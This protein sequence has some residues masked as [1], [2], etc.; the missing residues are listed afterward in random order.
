MFAVVNVN[1][2]NEDVEPYSVRSSTRNFYAGIS[3][4]KVAVLYTYIPD[5]GLGFANAWLVDY[6]A[7]VSSMTGKG[8]TGT[9]S[10]GIHWYVLCHDVAY[11]DVLEIYPALYNV[12]LISAQYD[13]ISATNIVAVYRHVLKPDVLKSVIV[14]CFAEIEGTRPIGCKLN[15]DLIFPSNR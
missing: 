12:A 9:V 4:S 7:N 15:N 13:V 3:T 11:D 5:H 14:R 10:A 2:I 1:P 8:A 6:Q